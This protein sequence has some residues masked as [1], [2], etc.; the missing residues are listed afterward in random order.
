MSKK[1]QKMQSCNSK[2]KSKPKEKPLLYSF[3]RNKYVQT[4]IEIDGQTCFSAFAGLRE[5][6][7]NFPLV[8]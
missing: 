3:T 5:L 7:L 1:Q 2:A 8:S 6:Y 4:L